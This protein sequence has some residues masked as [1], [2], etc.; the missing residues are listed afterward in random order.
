MTFIEAFMPDFIKV[1]FMHD[2]IFNF[3]DY[4]SFLFLTTEL[5]YRN[6]NH[7]QPET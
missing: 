2:F 3:I 4:F 1:F 5:E 6:E 7:S